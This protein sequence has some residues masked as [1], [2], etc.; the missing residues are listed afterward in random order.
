MSSTKQDSPLQ[1][2]GKGA[3]DLY[4]RQK[5]REQLEAIKSALEMEEKKKSTEPALNRGQEQPEAIKRPLEKEEK[6]KSTEP[7]LNRGQEQPE[8]IKRTLEKEETPESAHDKDFEGGFGGQEYLED[9]YATTCGE[10]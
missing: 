8:A 4:V 7:A 2:R 3:E 5:E 1:S 6:K 9:R 10:H